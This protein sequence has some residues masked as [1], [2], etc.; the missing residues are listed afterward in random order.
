LR[1]A[2][3]VGASADYANAESGWSVKKLNVEAMVTT[4]SPC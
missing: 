1:R 2:P 4:S 3:A